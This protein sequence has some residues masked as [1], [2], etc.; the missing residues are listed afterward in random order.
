MHTLE[1]LRM[2]IYDYTVS[3]DFCRIVNTYLRI[4]TEVC[5]EECVDKIVYGFT[6]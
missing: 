1:Y 3:V 2:A 6:I 4:N 5:D